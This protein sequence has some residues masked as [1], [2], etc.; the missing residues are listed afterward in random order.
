MRTL[1]II[2]LLALST[3]P[4]GYVLT[5]AVPDRQFGT[6]PYHF[7]DLDSAVYGRHLS[8]GGFD[9]PWFSTGILIKKGATVSVTAKGSMSVSGLDRKGDIHFREFDPDGIWLDGEGTDNLGQL[10]GRIKPK[11]GE[12][13]YFDHFPIGK[14]FITRSREDGVLELNMVP[15]RLRSGNWWNSDWATPNGK[16]HVFITVID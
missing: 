3:P 14:K 9:L 2:L 1:G 7:V 15:T 5:T 12:L 11:V 6:S 16:Y 13:N 10:R 8:P 4:N